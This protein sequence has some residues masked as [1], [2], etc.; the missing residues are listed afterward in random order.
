MGSIAVGKTVLASAVANGGTV[1]V[2]YPSGT[3][4]AA[5]NGSTSGSV[6]VEPGDSFKQAASGDGTVAFTFGASNIT[7][8]NNTGVAWPA[9]ATVTYSFGQTARKGSYNLTL[10]TEFNQAK[11]GNA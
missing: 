7:I 10:G 6:A 3:D 1:T 5:L 9:G 2:S 8:T 4:Q 11:R